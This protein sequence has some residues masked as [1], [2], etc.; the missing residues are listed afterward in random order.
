MHI[1]LDGYIALHHMC[2][3]AQLYSYTYM[4]VAVDCFDYIAKL[5]IYV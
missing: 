1:Y 3:P 2:K 4:S 5:Y